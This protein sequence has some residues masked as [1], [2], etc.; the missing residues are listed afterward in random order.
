VLEALP[1]SDLQPLQ[2][3]AERC[4]E[5]MKMSNLDDSWTDTVLFYA[6][7]VNS[8]LTTNVAD[9]DNLVFVH[10]PITHI[11]FVKLEMTSLATSDD[12]EQT[13]Q[14]G[15][16]PWVAKGELNYDFYLK[17][18]KQLQKLKENIQAMLRE[19]DLASFPEIETS[20]SQDR[21]TLVHTLLY[22]WRYRF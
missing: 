10:R 4:L 13:F 14:A 6:F 19:E 5:A 1:L 15:F 12:D 11:V 21:V 7:L 22:Q 3:V 8:V 18:K 2:A 16:P 9:S 20:G 17:Q